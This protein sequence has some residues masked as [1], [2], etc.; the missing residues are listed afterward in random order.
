MPSH[1]IRDHRRCLKAV[2]EPW[3]SAAFNLNELIAASFDALPVSSTATINSVL[4]YSVFHC[5]APATVGCCTHSLSVL[6]PSFA[7][8]FH[9]Q[10]VSQTSVKVAVTGTLCS[11]VHVADVLAPN[12]TNL[13][14]EAVVPSCCIDAS[15]FIA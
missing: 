1:L 10:S 14:G 5:T 4:W 2:N 7:V 3:Q 6:L 8:A 15:R 12:G 13:F 11:A 9:L